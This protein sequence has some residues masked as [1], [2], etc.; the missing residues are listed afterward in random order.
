MRNV[1]FDT[2]VYHQPGIE[3]LHRVIGTG[4]ILFASEML[5]AVRGVNPDTGFDWDDTKGYID[6][7]GL[8]RDDARDV[9]ERNARRVYPRIDASLKAAGSSGNGPPATAVLPARRVTCPPCYCVPCCLRR[10][11]VTES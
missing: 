9:F 11:G 6:R 3:L 5:G 2:C 7:L 4:N 8:S 10:R 1:F